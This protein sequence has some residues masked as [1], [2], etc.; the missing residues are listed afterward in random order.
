M[1]DSLEVYRKGVSQVDPIVH[2]I[3]V[4]IY[5]HPRW[6]HYMQEKLPFIAVTNCKRCAVSICV[7]M[8]KLILVESFLK[9]YRISSCYFLFFFFSWGTFVSFFSKISISNNLKYLYLKTCLSRSKNSIVC[10]CLQIFTCK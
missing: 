4:K 7:W 5:K 3:S 10:I 6:K 2:L 1:Y 8:I 9:V